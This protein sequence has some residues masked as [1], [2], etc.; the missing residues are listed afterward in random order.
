MRRD[1]RRRLAE[2][3]EIGHTGGKVKFTVLTD[4]QGGR[5]YRIGIQLSG[6]GPA[7]VFAIYALPPAIPVETI[8]MGGIGTPWNA[9]P[10]QGAFPVFIASDS[11]GWFG[12]QCHACQGYWRAQQM[13]GVCAYCGLKGRAHRF[14]TEAQGR[15]VA[16]YIARLQDA[17]SDPVDAVHVIDMDEVA[18]A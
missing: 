11:E 16:A 8:I 6:A 18:S 2:F 12:Q 15:Y 14:V 1:R 3:E 7:K 10:V 17:L 9:P 5:K 13:P 4:E